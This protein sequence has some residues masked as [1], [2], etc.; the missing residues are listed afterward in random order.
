MNGLRGVALALII[1]GVLGLTYG[2]FTYTKETHKA[3]IGSL[4][5]SVDEEQ[6][7]NVPIWLGIGALVFGGIL[8]LVGRKN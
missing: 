3:D 2:G 1:A 6:R 5:L 7:V 4:H 8:L